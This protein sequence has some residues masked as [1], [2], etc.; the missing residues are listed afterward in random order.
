M[1][2]SLYCVLHMNIAFFATDSGLM[3][4]RKISAE[5]EIFAGFAASRQLMRR[6][7]AEQSIHPPT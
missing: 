1:N 2:G 6:A 7:V 5:R 3:D 4:A